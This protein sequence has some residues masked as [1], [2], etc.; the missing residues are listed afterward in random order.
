MDFYLFN[1][2]SRSKI[3]SYPREYREFA[4]S[5]GY[6]YLCDNI[7]NRAILMLVF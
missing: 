5:I 6:F 7:F 2:V 1:D 3:A 4:I